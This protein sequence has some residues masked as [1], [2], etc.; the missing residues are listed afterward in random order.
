MADR[1]RRFTGA[2]A[3]M[4]LVL[5]A[6]S[7]LARAATFTVVTPTELSIAITAANSIPGANHQFQRQ[8]H[9]EQCPSRNHL[10]EHL[11]DQWQRVH[12]GWRELL[13]NSQ[14]ELRRD[15]QPAISDTEGRQ[16]DRLRWCH[17]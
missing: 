7:G 12:F 8:Y 3:V 16:R 4:P 13:S 11:D 9:A 10:R 1:N 14:R 2:V 15:A 17:P 6:M 5:L